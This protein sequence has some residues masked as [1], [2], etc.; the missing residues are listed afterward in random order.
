MVLTDC[1]CGS[2]PIYGG[3]PAWPAIEV[4]EVDTEAEA[5]ARIAVLKRWDRWRAARGEV[6]KRWAVHLRGRHCTEGPG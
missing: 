1:G 2:L 6:A 3:D 5:I 4:E